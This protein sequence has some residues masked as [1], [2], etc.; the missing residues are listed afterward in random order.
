MM[1][2]EEI[3]KEVQM[4]TLNRRDMERFHSYINRYEN[5]LRQ[6]KELGCPSSEPKYI[7]V[8]QELE[9]YRYCLYAAEKKAPFIRKNKAADIRYRDQQIEEFC[10]KVLRTIPE[11]SDL[12]F[13][14]TPIYLAK[15][16]IASHKISSVAE[17][18]NGYVHSTDL[19]GKY[20]FQTETPYPEQLHSFWI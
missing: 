20:R 17:R 6:L 9:R 7:Q 8:E 1:I 2:F 15:E 19:H 12:R 11:D 5:Q 4:K 10:E 16:I 13:H 3:K 18:F 14:G